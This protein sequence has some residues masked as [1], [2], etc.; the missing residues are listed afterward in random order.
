MLNSAG[1]HSRRR[2]RRSVAQRFARQEHMLHAFLC[3][4][5]ANEAEER[6]AFEIKQILFGDQRA[7]RYRAA[8]KDTDQVVRDLLIMF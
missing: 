5:F 4:R 7:P 6:L 8:R 1:A 2:I 3:L